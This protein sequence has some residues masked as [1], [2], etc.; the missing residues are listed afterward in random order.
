MVRQKEKGEDKIKLFFMGPR[1]GQFII[2][3]GLGQS[4]VPDPIP[5]TQLSTLKAHGLTV[6]RVFLCGLERPDGTRMEDNTKGCVVD[7][8]AQRLHCVREE[9][10]PER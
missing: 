8:P 5:E 6:S 1:Q 9:T 2:K 10:G 3:A 4:D 7:D